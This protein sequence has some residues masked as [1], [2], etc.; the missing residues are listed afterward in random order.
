MQNIIC[1]TRVRFFRD[2][3]GYSLPNVHPSTDD[4]FD[5]EWTC[6]FCSTVADPNRIE[7]ALA[8]VGRD[9]AAMNR[10]DP[11]HCHMFL[12]H[13]VSAGDLHPNH[14]YFTE[15]RLNLAQLYGQLEGQPLDTLSTEQLSHKRELCLKV[16]KVADVLFPGEFFKP[17]CVPRYYSYILCRIRIREG[18]VFVYLSLLLSFL[19]R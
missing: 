9:M 12:D 17:F 19:F 14:Y 5:V 2:C 16:L 7:L 11:K 1:V 4:P 6:N 8:H 15:V 10:R 18:V 3:M 13:Y